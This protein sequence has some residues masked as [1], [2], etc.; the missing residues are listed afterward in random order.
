MRAIWKGWQSTRPPRSSRWGPAASSGTSSFKMRKQ[1]E[2]GQGQTLPHPLGPSPPAALGRSFYIAGKDG[3]TWPPL[4]LSKHPPL[5]SQIL[6]RKYTG[7]GPV[8]MNKLLFRFGSRHRLRLVKRPKR[9]ACRK[10]VSRYVLKE[11]LGTNIALLIHSNDFL[12][13]TPLNAR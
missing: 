10:N 9:C 11:C 1:A 2:E 5:L 13:S 4:R 12:L 6:Q 7:N 8:K 3:A